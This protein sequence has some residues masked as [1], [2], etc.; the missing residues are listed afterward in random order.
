MEALM[1]DVEN[2]SPQ[3]LNNTEGWENSKSIINSLILCSDIKFKPVKVY[4]TLKLHLHINLNLGFDNSDN[5]ETR[6]SIHSF[7]GDVTNLTIEE[8]AYHELGE[9]KQVRFHKWQCT[10]NSE[11]KYNVHVGSVF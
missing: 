11:R 2:V 5:L 6:S 1:S 3:D 10:K 9:T 7:D 4:L 8:L